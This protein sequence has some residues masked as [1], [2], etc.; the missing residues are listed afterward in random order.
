MQYYVVKMLLKIDVVFIPPEIMTA[1]G[2]DISKNYDWIMIGG[3]PALR[4]QK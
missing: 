2:L 1:F 4:E 3:L